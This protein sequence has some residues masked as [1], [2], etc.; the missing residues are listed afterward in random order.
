M[1]SGVS[2]DLSRGGN[3]KDYIITVREIKDRSIRGFV[4]NCLRG[5]LWATTVGASWDPSRERP[6]EYVVVRQASQNSAVGG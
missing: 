2:R 5:R 4:E 3:V 1:N 6:R